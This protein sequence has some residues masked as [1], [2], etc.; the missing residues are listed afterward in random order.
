MIG[1][2]TLPILGRGVGRFRGGAETRNPFGQ[3]GQ[4]RNNYFF[5]CIWGSRAGAP[6]RTSKG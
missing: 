5:W 1:G 4:L 2:V 6:L 3:S